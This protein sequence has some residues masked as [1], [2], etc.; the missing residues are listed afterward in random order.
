MRFTDWTVLACALASS[1][2][3]DL[4]AQRPDFA[5]R[6]Q[7]A[8]PTADASATTPMPIQTTQLRGP[9]DRLQVTLK[10]EGVERSVAVRVLSSVTVGETPR[11]PTEWIPPGEGRV[12]LHVA[13]F[14]GETI[15]G[16]GAAAWDPTGAQSGV[17]LVPYDPRCDADGDTFSTC[18]DGCC[19][20]LPPEVRP[21]VFDCLDDPNTV[22]P[23]SLL[24][25][26]RRDVRR[27]H[28]FA[29]RESDTDYALCQ[30]G[31]DDDCTGADVRCKLRQDADRDGV[32]LVDDCDD[33]KPEVGPDV[34]EVP[35]DGVDQ[36]CDGRDVAG[37]D[38]DGD[39]Y[40]ARAP[41]QGGAVD[42]DDEDAS[43]APGHVEA[44]CDGVDQDCDGAD[45]CAGGAA[46]R[47]GD[48]DS[49]A[50][51]DRPDCDDD[52]A[53]RRPG[54]PERCGDGVDQDCDGLDAACD[55]R[56]LD[57][58]GSRA[59][60]DCDDGDPTRFPGAPERC[61]DGV[62]QSCDGIDARCDDGFDRDRDGWTVPGDCD[63]RDTTVHPGRVERCD[64]R[65]EDCDGRADEGNPD[66]DGQDQPPNGRCERDCGGGRWYCVAAAFVCRFP[67]TTA[68]LCDGL[69]ND[70]DFRTDE[71][72]TRTCYGGA[73]E[74]LDVGLCRAGV[75][76]CVGGRPT[77]C[78]DAVQPTPDVTCDGLDQD[79]D[80]LTDEA[81]ACE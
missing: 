12:Y 75:E 29:P 22:R 70:C 67:P 10:R 80:G 48:G 26:K 1:A 13:A 30:N 54:L 45:V 27:A 64:G 57:R 81:L 73:A 42:C 17:T 58:D 8:G 20:A 63:D 60:N 65:D 32:S 71:D 31:L 14:A 4:D 79:C 66:R 77:P 72:T 74:T 49:P 25:A 16:T 52:D 50:D 6:A 59:G 36:N 37:N 3:L 78:M 9:I 40:F 62:D 18:A 53:G 15:L 61:D 55:P 35:G 44:P 68:E 34:P 76:R 38:R 28:A 24:D 23:P 2:C 69:D 33:L 41:E 46:D 51:A 47:D 39:G 19:D 43:R 21:A 11:V 56:D 7:D 5:A